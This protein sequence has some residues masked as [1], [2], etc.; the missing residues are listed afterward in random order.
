MAELHSGE[1]FIT[2][3]V[4][5]CCH[6]TNQ[7]LAVQIV[8]TLGTQYSQATGIQIINDKTWK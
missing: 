7:H 4:S 5:M 3:N 1:C 6:K 2:Q 8:N